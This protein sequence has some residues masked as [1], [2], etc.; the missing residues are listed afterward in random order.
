MPSLM[1][2]PRFMFFDD[3]CSIPRAVCEGVCSTD[4]MSNVFALLTQVGP[5]QLD[6]M[7]IMGGEGLCSKVAVRRQLKISH[8]FD[9]VSGSDLRDLASSTHSRVMWLHINRV[10]L[11]WLPC[12]RLLGQLGVLT[13]L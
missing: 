5:G 12:A 2:F 11:W 3:L 8:N 9:I 13:E 7:E 10:V 1:N 4:S 6:V